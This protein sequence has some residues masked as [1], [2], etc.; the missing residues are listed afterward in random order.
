MMTMIALV[1][2]ILIIIIMM[3][4]MMMMAIVVMG[5]IITMKMIRITQEDDRNVTMMIENG[6]FSRPLDPEKLCESLVGPY[7][8]CLQ[9][10][11]QIYNEKEFV[12]ESSHLQSL[13]CDKCTVCC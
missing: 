8:F 13:S 4:M 7:D 12:D 2:K 11:A 5:K 3:M 10:S 1:F 6:R 9:F